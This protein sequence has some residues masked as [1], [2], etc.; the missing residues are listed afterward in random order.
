V[1]KSIIFS[2]FYI[3]GSI[4]LFDYNVV[5]LCLYFL[6]HV[7]PTKEMESLSDLLLVLCSH[8]SYVLCVGWNKG[9]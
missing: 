1:W 2:Y 4:V 3:V 7:F 9:S 6:S 5:T 8:P